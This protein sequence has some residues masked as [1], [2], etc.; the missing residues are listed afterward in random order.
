MTDTP[1]RD[2]SDTAYW[3]AHHRANESERPDA[4][5]SDPLARRLAGDLGARIA[6]GLPAQ[7]FI[8]W[9]VAVRTR[10]IDDFL[11]RA[12]VQ[13]ADTVLNL[14]AGLDTRPYR[15]PLPAALRWVEAD[16]AH[17]MAYKKE[18]L[19]GEQPHC[20]LD[21]VSLDLS[22]PEARRR[23]LAEV[24]SRSGKLLV[25]TE[26]LMPYLSEDEG[27]ALAR[28]LRA[29]DHARWWIVDYV[30]RQALA[31]RERGGMAKK[32]QNAPFRFDPDDWE[33]FFRSR[34][35][36]CRDMRFMP[37]EGERLG[38]PFPVPGIMRWVMR[39]APEAKKKA[40]RELMG[41]ALMEPCQVR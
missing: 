14:G 30:S 21:S 39:L 27:S 5:F 22:D 37:V 33:D 32:M 2:V 20:Q 12:I 1:I 4:L 16:Q 24:N 38:R 41:Y 13:G 11:A 26:G 10:I 19:A 31:Y 18:K 17:I 3:I 34:G 23:M 8:A 15:M 29:L 7:R 25:L 9:N 28:D 40:F 35:W 6:H 36:E